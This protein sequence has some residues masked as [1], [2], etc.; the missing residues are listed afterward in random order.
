MKLYADVADPRTNMIPITAKYAGFN[1]LLYPQA[2][3]SA[4]GR[5]PILDMGLGCIFTSGAIAR[6][7][8]RVRGDLGLFG[9]NLLQSSVVDSWVEFG[10]H[11]L[12][13]PL[14]TWVQHARGATQAPPELVNLAKEDTRKAAMILNKHLLLSTYITGHELTLA[15]IS[16]YCALADGFASVFDVSFR[17][18]FQNLCRWFDLCAA[19]PQFAS[20]VDDAAAPAVASAPLTS[21]SAAANGSGDIVAAINAVGN[22]IRVL[23]ERLK[24]EGLSAK[25]VNVHAE[26][27]EKV[28][29]LQALKAQQGA[30]PAAFAP[31]PRGVAA[32]QQGAAAEDSLDAQITAAGQQI[33]TLKERLKA[34]GQSPND[35][36][37]VKALVAQLQALK[38]QAPAPAP[39]A[40]AAA[41]TDAPAAL[42][43]DVDAQI[44]TVGNEIRAL[45]EKFKGEGLSK[46]EVND[47][48]EIKK[49]VA[50]LQDLKKNGAKA[51]AQA[52]APAKPAAVP[53]IDAEAARKAKL[54]KVIKEGGKRGVEIEGAADMGGLGYFCTS[55]DEPDGNM[56]MMDACMA[57]MNEESMPDEE[58]RKGGSGK[59]GKMIF[60]AGVDQ[61]AIIAYVPE[62]KKDAI[63]AIEWL[64]KVLE[65]NGGEVVSGS[66]SLYARGIVKADQDKAKFPLKMKEPSIMEAC[67]F[68]KQKGLFPDDD[69]DDDMVFGDDDF[70]S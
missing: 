53:V 25:Q 21:S 7:F 29:R 42:A 68:L 40:P 64:K 31:P 18:E 12:E 14:R 54:K 30:A 28:Q 52:P 62:E 26:V 41:K 5:M 55:V 43:G 58:E 1:L 45:K 60:S 38:K 4:L 9:H 2:P 44:T 24:G 65:L 47:N 6:Y 66:T 22:D 49:L 69:S 46:K 15:D 70:P 56:E 23:K 48:E 11:D 16:L 13:V 61:L 32:P 10:T 63:C 17:K 8:A 27:I 51:P 20:A 67:S 59:I 39:A 33:R 19:Q 57:A 35:N 50:Q 34:E 37:E 36:E 3:G